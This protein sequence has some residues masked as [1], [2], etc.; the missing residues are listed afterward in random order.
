MTSHLDE[1][2]AAH[3]HSIDFFAA[4]RI[5]V[6]RTQGGRDGIDGFERRHGN[7]LRKVRR[8]LAR[9]LFFAGMVLLVAGVGCSQRIHG[10]LLGDPG[11]PES[12]GGPVASSGA[13]DGSGV[14]PCPVA[15]ARPDRARPA[16]AA[17]Q[18]RAVPTL[19][20][21]RNTC[22]EDQCIDTSSDAAN[23]GACGNACEGENA[24][25]VCVESECTITSCHDGYVDCSA[26]EPG[27]ETEDAGLPGSPAPSCRWQALTRVRCAREVAEAEVCVASTRR[28]R[29]VRRAHL[30]GRADPR[31]VPG[32]LQE[33]SLR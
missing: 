2:K 26:E 18:A 14:E 31:C 25:F 13:E 8:G 33:C 21:M 3:R 32:E 11:Y 1:S 19:A 4:V 23:C 17:A 24:E 15:Q 5:D 30:R 12:E 16:R 27:C 28:G 9:H 10:D 6:A 7:R 29:V 22:C 20:A